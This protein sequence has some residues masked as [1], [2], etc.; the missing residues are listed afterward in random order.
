MRSWRPV[1]DLRTGDCRRYR[2]SARDSFGQSDYVGNKVEVLA[3]EHAAGTAHARLHLV[4]D[5]QD[6]VPVREFLEFV[7]ELLWR[8]HVAAFALYR[9]DEDRRDFVSRGDVA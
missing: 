5:Q 7:E 3:R 1:H 6:V 8:D 2:H 9:L 4:G